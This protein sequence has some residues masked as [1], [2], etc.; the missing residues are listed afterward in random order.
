MGAIF[1]ILGIVFILAGFGCSIVILID[2]FQDSVVKGIL[3]ILCG[4]YGL[5][6]ALFEFEHENKWLIVLGSFLCSGMAAV[7]FR[8]AG[9]GGVGSG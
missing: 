1:S 7:F 6:Y 9:Y 5:Y 4:F 2:A 3:C 8:M